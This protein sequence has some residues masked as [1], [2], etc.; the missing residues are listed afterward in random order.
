MYFDAIPYLR[1]E[2]IYIYMQKESLT[3]C[4]F[5]IVKFLFKYK[6]HESFIM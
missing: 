5:K 1:I 4:A 6:T 2:Y 3:I